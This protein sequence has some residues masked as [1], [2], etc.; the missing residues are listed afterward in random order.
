MPEA[1]GKF[2]EKR[3]LEFAAN[4]ESVAGVAEN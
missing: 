1:T 4:S 3:A 2:A